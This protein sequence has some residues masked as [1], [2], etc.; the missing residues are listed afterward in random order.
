MEFKINRNVLLDNLNKANRIIDFKAVNPTLTGI[1]LDVS[2]NQ[3]TIT[4]TN[5]SLSFKAYLNSDNAQLEVATTGKILLKGKYILEMLRRLDQEIVTLVNI[6]NSELTIKNSNTEFNCGLLESE[7]YPLLGFKERGVEI[8][9]KPTSFRR[10]LSQTIVSIDET[11]KK[12]ILTGMNFRI[13]N[14]ALMVST[15]DMHRISQKKISLDI[16]SSTQCNVTVPYKTVVELMRLLDGVKV[17]KMV[18]SEGYLTFLMDNMVF[19]STLI[20]GQYPLVEGVFPKDFNLTLKVNQKV[21]LKALSRAD[22]S[23]ETGL[24]P[25]INLNIQQTKMVMK[26]DLVEI[27]NFEEDF[28][29]FESDATMPMTINFNLKYLIEAIRSFNDNLELKFVG[30]TNPLLI[31]QVDDENLKQVILPTYISN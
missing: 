15:T 30:S 11:N 4:S 6:E 25:I 22:L 18:V 5:N 24:A 19:Q 20:D 3:V 12:M 21:F 9:L 28:F 16:D 27:G 1:L 14:Q 17:L 29:D 10:A 13:Q 7:E 26:A 23:A 2:P 31:T 8:N